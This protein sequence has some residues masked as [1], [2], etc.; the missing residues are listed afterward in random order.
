MDTNDTRV[1]ELSQLIDRR[2]LLMRT[3]ADSLESSSS[4]LV[5][6]DVQAIARGAAHQAELC[7]QWGHLE[8]GLRQATGRSSPSLSQSTPQVPPA[9]ASGG[10]SLE[11]STRLQ[12]EWDILAIRIRYLTRVHRSLLRH[13]H[14]SLAILNRVVDSCAPTYTPDPVM[15]RMELRLELQRSAGE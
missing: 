10:S 6:N 8:N 3:L 13:L 15:L 1:P 14:R 7:R 4:L 2:L 12:A 11:R 9:L 5:R